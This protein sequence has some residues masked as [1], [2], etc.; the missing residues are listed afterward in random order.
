MPQHMLEC[1]LYRGA[2]GWEQLSPNFCLL[3][4]QGSFRL[5]LCGV[6]YKPR[7]GGSGS[8]DALSGV[9][10]TGVMGRGAAWGRHSYSAHAHTHRSLH[11]EPMP[12]AS[13]QCRLRRADA[14]LGEG[15]GQKWGDGSTVWK[16]L[17]RQL[18][19]AQLIFVPEQTLAPS[20]SRGYR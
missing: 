13:L 15:G 12:A 7:P 9:Q 11:G 6:F 10:L 14:A 4:L 19:K 5:A 17:A 16:V 3:S 20:P 8:G 2:G 18:G 1:A